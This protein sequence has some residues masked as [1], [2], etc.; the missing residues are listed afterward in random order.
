MQLKILE[1]MLEK[2]LFFF[3][4]Q[5]N[6]NVAFRPHNQTKTVS[7]EVW[8]LSTDEWIPA[9]LMSFLMLQNMLKNYKTGDENC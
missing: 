5:I 2:C 9:K 1:Q 7:E 4:D 8:M 6:C 3:A